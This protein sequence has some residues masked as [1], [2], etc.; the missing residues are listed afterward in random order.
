MTITDLTNT[1]GVNPPAL[2]Q[3]ITREVQL[4]RQLS[5]FVRLFQSGSESLSTHADPQVPP[6]ALEQ[7][8]LS[9]ETGGN[10]SRSIR[11]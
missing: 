3:Y 1:V 9:N 11:F 5:Y 4:T 8:V 6:N 7:S 10:P 2:N